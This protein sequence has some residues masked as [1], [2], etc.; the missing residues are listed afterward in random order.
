MQRDGLSRGVELH[1]GAD[2]EENLHHAR[3]F[4][5]RAAGGQHRARKQHGGNWHRFFQTAESPFCVVRSVRVRQ[6]RDRRL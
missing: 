6:I 2:A 4:G 5:F 3:S 1:D